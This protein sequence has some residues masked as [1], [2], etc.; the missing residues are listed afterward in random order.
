W[1]MIVGGVMLYSGIVNSLNAVINSE[2]EK[3]R[4]RAVFDQESGAYTRKEFGKLLVKRIQQPGHGV[5]TFALVF[6]E[7]VYEE[8]SL[9]AE[10]RHAIFK[11]FV[12]SIQ[13]KLGKQVIVS[14]YSGLSMTALISCTGVVDATQSMLHGLY[15]DLERITA[16]C[17]AKL[18]CG[19][20]VAPSTF[21][22]IH[23][24]TDDARRALRQA[25]TQTEK[26]VIFLRGEKKTDARDYMA[27]VIAGS[28]SEILQGAK[29]AY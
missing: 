11:E 28:F 10:S 7:L 29:G 17:G 4:L 21:T 27:D 16:R 13:Q 2:K 18:F 1:F 26:C 3:A 23:V 20:V 22:E 8:N 9:A 14:R 24:M 5:K 6:I 19:A 12:D 25:K 15:G